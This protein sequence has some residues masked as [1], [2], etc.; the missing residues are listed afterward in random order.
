[1]T[2]QHFPDSYDDKDDYTDADELDFDAAG[3]DNSLSTDYGDNEAEDNQ[4]AGAIALGAVFLLVIA[5]GLYSAVRSYFRQPVVQEVIVVEQV[6]VAQEQP[7]VM[8]TEE[9]IVPVVEQPIMSRPMVVE[10]SGAIRELKNQ[11]TSTQGRLDEQTDQ[12]DNLVSDLNEIRAETRVTNK[13][14]TEVESSIDGL[15]DRLIEIMEEVRKIQ[16][17]QVSQHADVIKE[18]PFQR[19]YLRALIDGRAWVQDE[20]GKTTTVKVGDQLGDYGTITG[21]HPEK[22]VMTTSSGK[23]IYFDSQDQ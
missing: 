7:E 17:N 11:L 13:K 20:S 16:V 8:M 4:G 19:Y 1:M 12:V 15:N 2:Q 10:D 5:Y 23:G 18:K 14:I 3:S 22:G 6:V 21:I 9:V